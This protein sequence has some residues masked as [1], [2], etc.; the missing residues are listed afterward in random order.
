M[1]LEQAIKKYHDGTIPEKGKGELATLFMEQFGYATK[2]SLLRVMSKER[3][4]TPIEWAWIEV[5]LE[6]YYEYYKGVQKLIEQEAEATE[7]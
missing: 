5:K 1:T 2:Q 4:A 6:E 7:V 3:I